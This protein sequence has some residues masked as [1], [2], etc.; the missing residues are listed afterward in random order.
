[1]RPVKLIIS[2]FGPY[3]DTMP[4]IDFTQ[5][6]EKGLFLISGDTGAGKTT[7]FDAICFA[8]YG[9]MSGSYRDTKSLRSEYAKDGTESF[10]DFYF[11]HQGHS[12]HV[13]RRP[14]YERRKLR[15]SGVTEVT[16]KA[17]L[18][19]DDKTPLEG[20][21]QVNAAIR[22]LL[23]IDD[24]QFKQIAMIA[25]GEFWELLN[26]KT[27]KRT[28][29]LRTIFMTG[30]YKSI[31]FKLKERMDAGLREKSSAENSILQYFT[32]VQTDENDDM[33][34]A[35]EAAKA[36][37][38]DA[39][40][41]WNLD[42]LLD[43]VSA[44]IASDTEKEEQESRKLE[45]AE[46]DLSESEKRLALAETQNGIL[47]RLEDL[48]KEK[49]QL[50]EQ[51][52]V[53]EEKKTVLQRQKSAVRIA[54][55]VCAS[56]KKKQGELIAVEGR[57]REKEE[58]LSEAGE[59][60]K[61]AARVLQEKEE[62]LPEAEALSMQASRIGEDKDK[63]QLRDQLRSSVKTLAQ[64]KE[65]LCGAEKALQEEE[66]QLRKKTV[67]LK[68]TAAGLKHKPE[69]LEKARTEARELGEL[70]KGISQVFGKKIPE[71]S[72]LREE[73]SEKQA[74]YLQA[75]E[76]Y[77]A[78]RDEREE[79]ERLLEN[80][81]A[82]ILAGRLKEGEKCPVCGSVHHPEPAHLPENAVDEAA[83]NTC[84]RNEKKKSEAKEKAVAA[85]EGC[86]KAL[87]QMEKQLSEEM[88]ILL[89]K[90]APENNGGSDPDALAEQLKEAWTL[91]RVRVRENDQRMKELE[92]SCRD[93][94]KAEEDLEKAQSVETERLAEKK[95]RLTGELRQNETDTV[96]AETALKPLEE[97]KYADWKTA[98][99]QKQRAENAAK[100]ITD[101]AE[102]ARSRKEAAEKQVTAI[103]SALETLRHTL[104]TQKEEE[105]RLH[106]QFLQVLADQGFAS[107]E[108]MASFVVTEAAIDA[109][110]KQIQKYERDTEV[111]ALSLKQTEKEAEGKTL[112]DEE[113]LR[114]SILEKRAK[115]KALRS[116][117]GDIRFRIA[118]NT[119]KL[120]G[121]KERRN[122]LERSRR[123]SAVC[124]R[125]YNLVRGQTGNG[126]I[127]L[128]QYIQAAGFDGI[129]RAA[130]RRLLPMSDHQYELYRQEDSLG[131]KSNTFLDLEV[132][133]NYTGHRRPVGNLSGGES[134][135]ASLSLALGLSDTVSSNLGGIQMD[136]L[137]VDEGFGT[138]DRKSIESAM[139]I[140]VHL[141]GNNKLV[142]VI[143]HRE[144]LIENIPQQIRVTKKKEGST[145]TVETG[146]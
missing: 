23:H 99:T 38:K 56:W 76:E 62:K 114:G 43:I 68:E 44:L 126:K 127:T 121:M 77:A 11:T 69:E 112:V 88:L 33:A 139:D 141:S 91:I 106:V 8:L 4:E 144:E 137:F 74:Q 123:E 131:K 2:A 34:E 42:E 146:L 117:V 49:K 66:E 107:E 32:G 86:K 39:K 100:L 20:L 136:A 133:D 81:R 95:Q 35:F 63:Y 109:D 83:L 129:I 124:A 18:Y 31:E 13:W 87:E 101:A 28:E 134:F 1:M 125:L 73:L 41:A 102:A 26:A 82:G 5:F 113:G 58:S 96:Q 78:A 115:V 61:A 29:I 103:S 53:I 12:Y 17:V 89:G 24:K 16:E 30:G 104:E 110:E 27:D 36:R 52:P 132:L 120:G 128:E 59:S 47:R 22:E 9:K 57:I 85:A 92:Q 55:P 71:R 60:A 122:V 140:L 50:E 65:E 54:E 45:E 143:S 46:K 118:S 40:S 105:G 97:L 72:R 75:Q 15:G 67:S 7:I 19:Q 94:T 138:L 135:K 84:R 6:E 116:A 98:E 142:G 79:T 90:A 48:R 119:E 37:A 51:R 25:Q 21:T 10:V 93:L 111:N 3:A 108:E 70:E 14:F 64:K 80:C 145:I 130:N